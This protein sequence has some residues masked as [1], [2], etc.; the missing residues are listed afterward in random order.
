MWRNSN[1]RSVANNSGNSMPRAA[2]EAKTSACRS[3]ASTAGTNSPQRNP[4]ESVHSSTR[5]TPQER[6]QNMRKLLPDRGGGEHR[7]TEERADSFDSLDVDTMKTDLFKNFEEA[8]TITVANNPGILHGAPTAIKSIKAALFKVQNVKAAK[9]AEMMKQ[10]DQAKSEIA[11]MEQQLSRQMEELAIKKNLCSKEMKT[12]VAAAMDLKQQMSEAEAEKTEMVKHLTFLSK[13]RMK[14][15]K[16]LQAEVKAV[17]K[18]RDALKSVVNER[19]KLKKVKEEEHKSLEDEV[20]RMSEEANK[21]MEML[22]EKKRELKELEEKNQNLRN[23]YESKKQ[24]LEKEQQDILDITKS[25]EAKKKR[26]ALFESEKNSKCKSQNKIVEMESQ[27]ARATLSSANQQK[28]L[29]HVVG[30]AIRSC[31]GDVATVH[32]V[33]LSDSIDAIVTSELNA[34]QESEDMDRI[35]RKTITKSL[36]NLDFSSDEALRRKQPKRKEVKMKRELDDLRMELEAIRE[37]NNIAMQIEEGRDAA[38]AMRDQMEDSNQRQYAMTPRENYSS[39]T[40]QFNSD[41]DYEDRYHNRD[42][43]L[44]SYST[45]PASRRYHLEDDEIR[46]SRRRYH[47][48]YSFNRKFSPPTRISSVTPRFRFSGE[49]RSRHWE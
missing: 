36:S 42:N 32:D 25:L 22:Q 11:N 35:I 31:M 27:L 7:S 45:S 1:D 24:K 26:T 19:K 30:G 43:N 5:T 14:L 18:D 40:P 29:A 46:P 49:Y 28:D 33:R 38:N 47:E 44:Y 23:E 15:E 8:F 9:E 12:L 6:F 37:R 4:N 34:R 2:Q 10:L 20:Q 48:D 39:P 41:R 17:E 16:A 13:S 21:E 3:A